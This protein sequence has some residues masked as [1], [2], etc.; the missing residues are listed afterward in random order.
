MNFEQKNSDV[1]CNGKDV[2][3]FVLANGEKRKDFV[4]LS[5]WAQLNWMKYSVERKVTLHSDSVVYA[6]MLQVSVVVELSV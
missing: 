3:N 2:E 1:I 5:W 4:R 6:A